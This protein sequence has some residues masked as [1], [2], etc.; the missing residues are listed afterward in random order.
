VYALRT[1]S[2]VLERARTMLRSARRMVLIDGFPGALA[3]LRPEII[4]ATGRGIDVA[5]KAY[6]PIELGGAEVFVHP[7]GDDVV[8][9]WA[10]EW[11]NVVTD[12]AEHLMSL[13]DPALAEIRQAVWSGSPYLSWVYHCALAAELMMAQV[14]ALAHAGPRNDRLRKLVHRYGALSASDLPGSRALR[15]R[16]ARPN[17]Q[18]KETP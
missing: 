14:S 3:A 18:T 10:G 5:I 17:P 15:K 8:A 12:G 6:R 7:E 4:A 2:Q 13:F 1:A 9:R 16:F 11:L